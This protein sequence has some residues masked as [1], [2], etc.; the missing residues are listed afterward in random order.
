MN[1]KLFVVI[2]VILI[3]LCGSGVGI[4]YFFYN[5]KMTVVL[6]EELT[7]SYMEKT[8]NLSFVQ[9]V[10][11]GK[12]TTKSENIDT[13]KLGKKKIKIKLKNKLGREEDYTFEIQVIDI[14][15]PEIV[16]K[17]TLSTTEGIPIDLLKDVKA[18]D[19]IDSDIKVTV[20]GEYDFNKEGNYILTY[21]AKDNSGNE[22]RKSFKLI[23][24][25]KKV[26]PKPSTKV[27]TSFTTSNGFKGYTKN[28]ITY[29]DGILIANKSYSL[30]SNYGSGLTNDTKTAFNNMKNDAAKEGLSLRIISG[31][32]SYASQKSVYNNYVARDGRAAA[33]RYSA[34]P[35]H[36]E[37]QTGLAIDINS[38]YQSFENT[39][40]GKWLTNNSYKYGFILRYPKNGEGITGYMYEPWH[41]RYVGVELA[42]KLYNQGNW[43][44]LEEYFGITSQYS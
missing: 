20:E 13:S 3:A 28:G 16:Y 34:R 12:I 9:E 10:K 36:S 30:P 32:R 1:K 37:H 26:I 29:I 7:V 5:Q 14:K 40:E 33:D 31:F 25:K 23:V 4:Y 19:D 11:N 44:T 43:I 15:P 42:T 21:V 8:T 38:L 39:N 18:I 35:G 41:F 27:D 17:D 22:T 24:N 2:G 6:K